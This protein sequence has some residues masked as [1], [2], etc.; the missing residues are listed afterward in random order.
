MIR[1][2]G[3]E[4]FLFATD[5]PMWDH[6]EELEK[7]NRLALTGEERD[8]ILHKNAEKVLGL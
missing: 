3:V 4:K 2:H 7:F 5:F 6:K 8:A 1:A